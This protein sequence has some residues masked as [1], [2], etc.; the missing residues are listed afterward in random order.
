MTPI[1]RL[2]PGY[3]TLFIPLFDNS[4]F[5]V[6]YFF[7]NPANSSAM[8]LSATSLLVPSPVLSFLCL[9]KKAF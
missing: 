4:R 9:L 8:A 3:Y 7:L 2:N 6:L 1:V 5:I